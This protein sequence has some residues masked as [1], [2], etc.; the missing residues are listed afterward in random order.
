M[1]QPLFF[2]LISAIAVA[3]LGVVSLL[4]AQEAAADLVPAA[5]ACALWSLP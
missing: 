3:V 2:S 5:L 4:L 1:S